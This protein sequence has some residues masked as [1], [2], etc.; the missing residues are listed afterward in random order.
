MG[1]AC[2]CIY[3]AC[4]YVTV[5]LIMLWVLFFSPLSLYFCNSG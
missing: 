2:K 1:W 5:I 3:W 4:K